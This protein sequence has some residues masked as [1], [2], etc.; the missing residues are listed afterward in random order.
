M[1]LADVDSTMVAGVIGAICT[2]LGGLVTATV[3]GFVLYRERRTK[4]AETTF[5][6]MRTVVEDL[7]AQVAAAIKKIEDLT[8]LH[9]DCERRSAGQAME[10]R[11][12]TE[13]SA[14][15]DQQIAALLQQNGMSGSGLHI[16]PNID[17]D[18]K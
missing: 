5:S 15:Q 14:K 2:G 6:Q 11:H 3:A 9:L 8:A 7:R 1:L 18:K 16:R 4:D 13:W 10:I 17:G 12:L